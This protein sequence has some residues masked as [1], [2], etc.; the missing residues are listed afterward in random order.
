M[1]YQKRSSEV[2]TVSMDI[3]INKTVNLGE[4]IDLTIRVTKK[5]IRDLLEIKY[6]ICQDFTILADDIPIGKKSK[7]ITKAVL[8]AILRQPSEAEA[9]AMTTHKPLRLIAQA[10][11]DEA[12]KNNKIQF[13]NSV[14]MELCNGNSEHLVGVNKLRMDEKYT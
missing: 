9:L 12:T 14:F 2:I 11:N 10:D 6:G 4:R 3:T 5:S 1:E 13:L 7:D 8:K